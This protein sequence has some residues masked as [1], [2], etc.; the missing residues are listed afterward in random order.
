MKKM[1]KSRL[2]LN[3]ET[4]AH[5]E[6]QDLGQIAGGTSSPK[7]CTFSGYQTCATCQNTC[8]TNYC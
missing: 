2:T 4:L 7:V 5:L 1:L 8:G 6:E 3:R